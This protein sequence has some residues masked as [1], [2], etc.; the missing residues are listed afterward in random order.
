MVKL[1]VIRYQEALNNDPVSL[2][3]LCLAL[4]AHQNE[5]GQVLEVCKIIS[6]DF[7]IIVQT[8]SLYLS[9]TDPLRMHLWK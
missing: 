5:A 2:S 6:P 1:L 4:P 3:I 7:T 8:L 9:E